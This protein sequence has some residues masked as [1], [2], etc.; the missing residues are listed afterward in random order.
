MLQ[1]FCARELLAVTNMQQVIFRQD[2]A[3]VHFSCKVSVFLHEQ[4]LNLWIDSSGPIELAPYSPYFTP[5]DFF[6]WGDI[7]SKVYETR[8]RDLPTLEEC[9]RNACA[10][11]TPKMLSDVSQA[12]IKRWFDCYEKGGAHVKMY[13]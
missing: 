10:S 11:V 6:L 5:C 4:F 7:K 2:G 13:R 1:E 9:I 8:P 3:P 12:C